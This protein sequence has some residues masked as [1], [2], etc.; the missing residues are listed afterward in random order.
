VHRLDVAEGQ[1]VLFRP[2]E[3]IADGSGVS[4]PGVGVADGGGEELDEA[5]A[6]LFP[7]VGDDGREDRPDGR[8]RDGSLPYFYELTHRHD[9]IAL[10]L[11]PATVY[12]FITYETACVSPSQAASCMQAIARLLP[13]C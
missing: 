8:C 2:G 3:E 10:E 1:A 6:S 9:P 5:F 7:G 4:L 11:G 12:S 13:I